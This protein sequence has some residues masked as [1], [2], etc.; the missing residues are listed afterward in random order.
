MNSLI[1]P[2]QGVAIANLT[3]TLAAT[4]IF[5]LPL[6]LISGGRFKE[7]QELLILTPVELAYENKIFGIIE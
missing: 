7:R 5:G 4:F 1:D 3:L 6:L 2:G